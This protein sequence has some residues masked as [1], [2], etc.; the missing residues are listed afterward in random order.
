[1]TTVLGALGVAAA[2]C[3]GVAAGPLLAHLNGP[4]R[5]GAAF[6]VGLVWVTTV[7]GLSALLGL[8]LAWRAAGVLIVCPP[9][10]WW[11]WR[12]RVAS[13]GGSIGRSGAPVVGR[14]P[15]WWGL[16]A[17]AAFLWAVV[18]G[19]AIATPLRF[20]DAWATYAF[21]AKIMYV[22]AGIPRSVF[23]LAGAPN[24]PLG[25]PFQEVW[26]AW[27]VGTWDDIAIKWLFPAYLLALM[28]LVYGALRERWSARAAMAGMLFVVGLPLLLQHAHDGY[29]DLPF[30]FFA[31]GSAIFLTRYALRRDRRDVF[32][33]AVLTA[34]LVWTKEDGVLF[35]AF[36]G[37][38]LIGWAAC[39]SGLTARSVS[40]DVGAYLALPALVWG[41]WTLVK[42][43]LAIP[44]NLRADVPSV[45]TLFDRGAVIADALSRS[46][47]LGGNWLIL[48][49]CFLLACIYWWRE[50]VLPESVFLFWPVVAYLAS[51]TVLFAT[52]DLYRYL[53][54]Q[55]VVH[56]LVLHVAPLAAYWVA[57]VFGRSWG[58]DRGRQGKE[59]TA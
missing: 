46:L 59:L 5:M 57:V 52:T 6:G 32:V 28:C 55:S 23:E 15:W 24:Y 33:A 4:Q 49:A 53:G 13:R 41:T 35:M 45:G 3:L 38:L 29:T 19:R 16:V 40:R 48:W 27:F 54:D 56:R 58:L 36:N 9:V 21:K 50:T 25:I 2:W 26:T 18:A 14:D 20:W 43:A 31:L 37:V 10:A 17:V 12:T 34:G 51:I 47:F 42:V 7:L 8:P 11:L 22:E 30:A 39:R 1:M 44:S